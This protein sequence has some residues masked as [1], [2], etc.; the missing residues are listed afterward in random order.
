MNER[1]LGIFGGTFDPVHRGHLQLATDAL[2]QLELEAV[3]WIPAG[4]PPLRDVPATPA[5]DR[6]AMVR[7]AIAG[8]EAFRLDDGEATREQP[9]YTVATL[10]RLRRQ[11]GERRPLV[12]LLGADAFARLEDW[13]RWRELFG[14]AHIAVASR[15]GHETK[16]GAGDTALDRE[17]RA[18]RA[19]P[20]ELANTPA[21]RIV[22]FAIA[23]VDVSA[24]ALRAQLGR[25]I[26]VGDGLADGVLDYIGRH[27]L[28]R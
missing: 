9:S 11:H 16:V 17:F 14:L 12:L 6:V 25:G 20:D 7:L 13:H 18:R 15:P 23:P 2:R 22:P 28:Y 8:R 4:R 26:D 10:E 3:L 24:T 1:P 21:G 5:A 27:R 19:A